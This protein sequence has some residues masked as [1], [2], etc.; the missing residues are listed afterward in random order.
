MEE[1]FSLLLVS[2]V[3]LLAL[4]QLCVGAKSETWD[5]CKQ[6]VLQMGYPCQNFTVT[7]DDGYLLGLYRI[8][9]GYN[10]EVKDRSWSRPPVYLQHG[11]VQ[12]GDTWVLNNPDESLGY[13]LADAGFDVWLGNIRGTRWSY[14]H[15]SMSREDKDYWDWSW[16]ELAAYDL[17]AMLEFVYKITGRKVLYV[18]HSQGTIMGLAAFTQDKVGEFVAAAALLSPITYLNHI[19][20]A[21][22]NVAAHYY[23]EKMVKTMGVHEFNLRNEL[24]VELVDRVCASP[25]VDCGNLLAALTG[26]NCCFNESRIPYYLQYEPHSTSLKNLA[27]L[28]QM[29]RSGTFAKYDYGRLGNLLHYYRFSPPSYDLAQI[30]ATMSLWM[31]WGGND[32]LADAVDVAHTISELQCKPELIYVENYGHIDFVLSTRAKTDIYDS[33]IAFFRDQGEDTHAQ[34]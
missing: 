5:I 3:A 24:G 29:I 13:I 32:A 18:G 12:G 7:T 21:F 19:N 15:V 22:L 10:E 28:A 20:S 31:S 23:I 9:Y 4:P 6:I 14:G 30:P 26:P 27:H 8:P 11:L 17:P 34:I 2:S 1:W 16:D 33:M 25:I